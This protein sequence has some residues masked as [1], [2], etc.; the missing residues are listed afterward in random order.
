MC[1]GKNEMEKSISRE[2]NLCNK[3]FI[4]LAK[5]VGP[6]IVGPMPVCLLP[7]WPLCLLLS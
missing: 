3:V 1:L 6:P 5:N 4:K 2:H 7:G